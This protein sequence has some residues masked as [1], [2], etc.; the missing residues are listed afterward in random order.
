M[1]T[2]YCALYYACA[3]CD[4]FVLSVIALVI[5]SS[6]R[7]SSYSSTSQLYYFDVFAACIIIVQYSRSTVR[8]VRH[9]N[10]LLATKRNIYIYICIYIYSKY[11]AHMYAMQ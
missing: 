3:L 6:T 9:Y 4:S 2:L 5:G 8:C 10:E 7:C 1:L 11:Y